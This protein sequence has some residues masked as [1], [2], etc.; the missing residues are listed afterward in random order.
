MAPTPNNIDDQI[1]KALANEDAELYEQFNSEPSLFGKAIESFRTQDRLATIVCI[2]G[3][4][5]CLGLLCFSLWRFMGA[6]DTK[7]QIGWGILF[8]FSMSGISMIKIWSW[9]EIQ[10]NNVTREVK[11]LELQV[12][13]LTQRLSESAEN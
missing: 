11:R 3:I 7:S 1:R 4:L 13:R 9:M 8:G 5:A 10:K 12:A 2:L 6:E